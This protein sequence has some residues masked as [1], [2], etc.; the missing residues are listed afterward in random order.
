MELQNFKGLPIKEYLTIGSYPYNRHS[1]IEKEAASYSKDIDVVCYSKDVPDTIVFIKR[2]EYAGTFIYNNKLIECLFA[3]KQ[4]SLQYLLANYKVPTF[5]ILYEIKL[6]HIIFPQKNWEKQLSYMQGI[7]YYLPADFEKTL[8]WDFIKLH[9]KCTKER[10]TIKNPPKLNGISKEKFFNDKV[11]KY[12]VHDDVHQWMAYG[13]KP[14][15]TKMQKNPDLVECSKD[16]WE[17]FS[18]LQKIRT[19]LEEAYVIA[20]ERH[21]IPQIINGT[22]GLNSQMAF[23]WALQ[24]ICTTLCSG[25]FRKFALTNYFEILD[26]RDKDYVNKFIKKADFTTI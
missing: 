11:T 23:K 7:A 14:L 15:Y 2:D 10:K 6:G 12:F 3:D 8:D 26:H 17:K 16:L 13:E 19:V 21:M 20:L 5:K 9:R 18:T 25:F 4:E 1:Y 22:P 24:R